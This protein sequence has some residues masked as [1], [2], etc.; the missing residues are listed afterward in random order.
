MKLLTE[1]TNGMHTNFLSGA[2]I[3]GDVRLAVSENIVQYY[4]GETDYN[5]QY[6]DDKNGLRVGRVEL[7]ANGT[8]RTLCFEE[9]DDTEAS[10]VCGQLGFSTC[11]KNEGIRREIY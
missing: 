3:D 8:Y 5:L 10:V 4:T 6:Y 1:C 7:C 2:C 9:W 11:G